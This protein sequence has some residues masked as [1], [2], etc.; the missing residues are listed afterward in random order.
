VNA[1]VADAV[2]A[3]EM[4]ALLEEAFNEVFSPEAQVGHLDLDTFFT[5]GR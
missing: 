5:P 3:W 4:K 2:T 1:L